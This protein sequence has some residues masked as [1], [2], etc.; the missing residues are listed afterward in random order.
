MAGGESPA[1]INV[2]DYV[3]IATTGNAVD[4]GDLSGTYRGMGTV[5]SPT[6]GVWGGAQ[7][8]NSVI[9]YIT[10]ASKGN[11]IDFGKLICTRSNVGYGSN[12]TRGGFAG[13]Y[14]GPARTGSI[15]SIIIATT[16]SSEYFGELT[17]RRDPQPCCSTHTR[18][19]FGN[20]Y[21]NDVG[22][23]SAR[24]DSIEL[25]SGGQAAHFGDSGG[26]MNCSAQGGCSDSHGGLGGF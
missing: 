12:I 16:G 13:G 20:G 8:T 17:V 18:T 1:N 21:S 24:Y 2:M 9:E 19:V 10:I 23:N 14:T 15:E 26:G 5:A 22:A 3:E 6:R 11:A 25:A 7:P 4:F